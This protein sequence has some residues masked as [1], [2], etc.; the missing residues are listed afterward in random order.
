MSGG[1]ARVVLWFDAAAEHR[2]AIATAASVAA[3]TRS[4][5]RG[6]FVEDEELLRLAR[7]RIARQVAWG[8]GT[9]PFGAEFVA[10]HLRAV[11]E[12]A[13]MELAAAAAARGLEW[14]FETLR[15]DLA[16][17]AA[18][19]TARDLVVAGM[20][21]R[22]VAGYF[23]VECRWWTSIG[24]A[25]GPV[26][27]SRGSWAAHGP[28]AVLLHARSPGSGRL[29]EAAARI[30]ELAGSG[31]VVS[32]A[33]ALVAAAGF[34]EWLADRL[35]GFSVQPEIETAPG[36]PAVLRRRIAELGCRLLALDPATI[37]GDDNRI[38]E[39]AALFAC[40]VLVAR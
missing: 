6:I 20:L 5:L 19:M 39:F 10:L 11:A 7:S 16:S 25:A 23:R 22:P 38:E 12:R 4:P 40:D 36:A 35:A 18:E 3:A 21:T 2:A 33:P 14:S 26:L 9:G 24:A 30:A 15:G 27:F 1:I 31:L 8:G 37:E 34:R 32:A 13:R 29:L 17:L 28:V